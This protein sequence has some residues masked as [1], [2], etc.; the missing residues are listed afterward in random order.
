MDI[1]YIIRI[2]VMP[3]KKNN[4]MTQAELDFLTQTPKLLKKVVDL[5]AEQNK[6]LEKLNNTL[7]ELELNNN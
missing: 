7:D 2:F 4:I 6:I 5:L 3:N 1:K